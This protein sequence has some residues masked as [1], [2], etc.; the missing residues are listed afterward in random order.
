MSNRKENM[1]K[2]HSFGID[3]VSKSYQIKKFSELDFIDSKL[4]P[5]ELKSK[6]IELL[7]TN[8][9]LPLTAII[10]FADWVIKINKSKTAIFG[11][12]LVFMATVPNAIKLAYNMSLELSSHEDSTI[13]LGLYKDDPIGDDHYI[14]FKR[15]ESSIFSEVGLN[16]TGVK[17]KKSTCYN[18]MIDDI[19][20]YCIDHAV[21]EKIKSK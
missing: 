21:K 17:K 1:S 14:S 15:E 7:A 18:D 4:T 11:P 5:S 8:V 16:H 6:I 9:N 13:F 20:S 10:K 19:Y 2:L 12:H 3:L